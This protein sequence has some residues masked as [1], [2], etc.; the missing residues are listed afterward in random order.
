MCWWLRPRLYGKK[1]Y[2]FLGEKV[3]SCHGKMYF[4]MN[5]SEFD[6]VIRFIGAVNDITSKG[7]KDDQK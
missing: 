1:P 7:E 3:I 4:N 2:T 6:D 5:L